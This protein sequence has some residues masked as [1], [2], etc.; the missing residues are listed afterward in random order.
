[1][2]DIIFKLPFVNEVVHFPAQSLQFSIFVNLAE[3]TLSIIL[4]HSKL[5]VDRAVGWGIPDNIFCV[6]DTKLL[7]FGLCCVEIVLVLKGTEHSLVVPGR[8]LKLVNELLRELWGR[9][10]SCRWQRSC[11]GFLWLIL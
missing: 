11:M 6:Q 4:A 10:Q 2:I 7:P 3:S 1:M 5:V 8:T 9:L